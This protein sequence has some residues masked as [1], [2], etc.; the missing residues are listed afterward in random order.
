M[1]ATKSCKIM[2]GVWAQV[3]LWKSPRATFA[4]HTP[5]AISMPIRNSA[6]TKEVRSPEKVAQIAQAVIAQIA[7]L[8]KPTIVAA[9]KSLGFMLSILGLDFLAW[10]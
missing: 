4:D 1:A 7:A 9:I 5:A 8:C 2:P 6:L 10:L 3:F